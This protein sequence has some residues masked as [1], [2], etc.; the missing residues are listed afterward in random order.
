VVQPDPGRLHDYETHPGQP[1]SA[2]I[3]GAMFE[4]YDEEA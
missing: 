3:D 4:R 2:E 1:A